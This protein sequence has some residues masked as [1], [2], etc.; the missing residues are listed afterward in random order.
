MKE[1]YGWYVPDD[2]QHFKG[3]FDAVG[4]GEYQKPQREVALSYCGKFR[5]AIDIGGHVGFWSRPL[6]E[7]F[8]EVVAFEP[9]PGYG[10][11]FRLNAPKANLIPVALGEE[12]R[13]VDLEIPEGNTGAAFVKDGSSYDMFPLDDYEFKDVDL[14]K[15]DVEGYEL[16]V[17][18]GARRTL[19]TNNP[20]IVVEQKPHPHFKDRW[21]RF[22]AIK[23]LCNGFGYRVMDKVVDDWILKRIME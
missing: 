7:V 16:G 18:R 21:D 5:K 9:H 4:E 15:I 22:D 6:S 13:T 23:F 17:L 2:D 20:I 3:Y 12:H 14:I 1:I 11:L 8:K 19:V 10:E